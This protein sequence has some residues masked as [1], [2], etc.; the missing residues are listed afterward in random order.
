[1]GLNSLRITWGRDLSSGNVFVKQ[2]LTSEEAK[3]K[4]FKQL[5][6]KCRGKFLG[7]RYI[8]NN[9]VSL[10]LIYD[11]HGDIAGIQMAVR[12]HSNISCFDSFE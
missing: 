12:N 7:Y 1:M 8:E 5:P 6:G 2:P 10:I 11:H 3:Q 4:G 9:D